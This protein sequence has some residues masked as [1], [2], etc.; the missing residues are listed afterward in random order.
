MGLYDEADVESMTNAELSHN[1]TDVEDL[2]EDW[3]FDYGTF[4]GNG[5]SVQAAAAHTRRALRL[6]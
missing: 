2:P 4:S 5:W 1:Q 6:R 3:H